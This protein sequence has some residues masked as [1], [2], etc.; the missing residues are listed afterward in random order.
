MIDTLPTLIL[1]I[2][3]AAVVILIGSLFIIVSNFHDKI[4]SLKQDIQ[5]R[6]HESTTQVTT[7]VAYETKHKLEALVKHLN[8]EIEEEPQ[9]YVVRTK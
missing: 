3:S 2:L 5:S 9:K 8:V 6:A 4:F 1:A 7:N